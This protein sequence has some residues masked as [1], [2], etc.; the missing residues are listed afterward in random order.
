MFVNKISRTPTSNRLQIGL[1][2]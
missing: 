2:G 1:F